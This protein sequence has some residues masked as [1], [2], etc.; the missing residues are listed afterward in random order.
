MMVNENPT[1]LEDVLMISI[2]IFLLLNIR[3]G[4]LLLEIRL[5]HYCYCE[6]VMHIQ[7]VCI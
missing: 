6:D 2:Y 7:W 1:H 4:K 3:L 5:G